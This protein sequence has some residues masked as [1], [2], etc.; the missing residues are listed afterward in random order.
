SLAALAERWE[1]GPVPRGFSLFDGADRGNHDH[2]RTIIHRVL[3][4]AFIGVGHAPARDRF[5]GR[6]RLPH[7][8]DRAPV[9]RV[10]L[11]LGPDEVIA[12]IRHRAVSFRTV[13]T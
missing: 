4:F 9:A 2:Q 10:V 3:D 5:G 8:G 1:H 13:G 12:G 7:A 11:H 6:T